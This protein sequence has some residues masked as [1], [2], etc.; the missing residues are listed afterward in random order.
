MTEQNPV[1][2]AEVI[3]RGADARERLAGVS[4]SQQMARA[5][6]VD[7]DAVRAEQERLRQDRKQRFDTLLGAVVLAATI[8]GALAGWL[9]TRDAL[10]ILIAVAVGLSGLIIT[11]GV[12]Y[13]KYGSSKKDGAR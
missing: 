7:L 9:V 2:P 13:W 1:P 6:G 5:M 3:A 4:L 11:A 10:A 12:S 8:L